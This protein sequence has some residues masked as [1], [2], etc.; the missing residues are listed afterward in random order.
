MS[1]CVFLIAHQRHFWNDIFH[2]YLHN[3]LQGETHFVAYWILL[4]VVAFAV[5]TLHF[6]FSFSQWNDMSKEQI[7]DS[8]EHL[9][10]LPLR[11]WLDGPTTTFVGQKLQWILDMVKTFEHYCD[12]LPFCWGLTEFRAIAIFRSYYKATTESTS[13]LANFEDGPA[14]GTMQQRQSLDTSRIERASS[15]RIEVCKE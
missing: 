14:S 11:K 5:F 12:N 2:K 4:E 10:T 15:L 13:G 3:K 9:M 1:V 7:I 6:L 8:R